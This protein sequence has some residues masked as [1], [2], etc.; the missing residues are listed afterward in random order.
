VAHVVVMPKLGLTMD[1]GAVTLWIATLGDRVKSGTV[2]A[3]ISSDKIT[4]EVEAEVEGVLAGILVEEDEEVPVGTPIA[5]I[6]EPGENVPAATPATQATQGAAATPAA[7]A[8]AS[9]SDGA[10]TRAVASPAARKLATQLGLDIGCI[11][12]SGPEGRVQLEDVT[13]AASQASIVESGPATPLDTPSSAADADP[14][15]G[16]AKEIPYTGMRRTIGERMDLSRRLAATVHYEGLADIHELKQALD[17]AG[18][19]APGLG[20]GFDSDAILTAAAVR[21]VALALLRMPRFNATLD[22]NVI[23]VWRNINIGVA[24]ALSKGLV[25]PVIKKANDK[26]LLHIADEIRDLAERGR[27]GKLLPDEVAG[28]T[29]TVTTLAPYGSVD[30]FSPIINQP[31]VAILGVGR[32]SDRVLAVDGATVIRATVGL[33]L[34]CDHRV[35]DGGPAAEFLGMVIDHL[36][37]PAAILG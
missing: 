34:G 2:I 31:E 36:A 21:A 4:Y 13:R 25:V 37:E 14:R 1:K 23:K 29:F 18:Q 6:G 32:V 24:V 5:L 33:S 9:A 7:Q 19:H 17:A 35:L 20:L 11:P 26:T 30:Y 22:G 16:A 27:D 28:G 3:E 15:G 12:G 10:G 8:D